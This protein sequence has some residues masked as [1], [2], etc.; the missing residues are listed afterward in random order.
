MHDIWESK[1]M[2]DTPEASSAVFYGFICST[3]PYPPLLGVF[4][5]PQNCF[6]ASAIDPKMA[7]YLQL[8]ANPIFLY[9][10]R[11]MPRDRYSWAGYPEKPCH[12]IRGDN[13]PWRMAVDNAS[14]TMVE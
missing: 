2:V 8:F 9:S 4:V 3:S 10:R 1:C 13:A 7:P 6:T 5:S 11:N 14:A 12:G